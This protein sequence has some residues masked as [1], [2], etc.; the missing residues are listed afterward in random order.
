MHWDDS[1]KVVKGIGDKTAGLLDKLGIYTVGDLVQY[2]P[3]DYDRYKDIVPISTISP[4][5]DV[6]IEGTLAA[7]PSSTKLRNLTI[8]NARLKD[9]TGSIKV[10]WFNMPF[11][12]R[13]LKM[14]TYYIMRGKVSYKNDSFVIEQPRMY[15]KQE[16]YSGR[17]KLLPIY[18]LTKGISNNNISKYIQTAVNTVD[19]END[20][21]PAKYCRENSLYSRTKAIRSIHYPA[22]RD[23]VIKARKRLA[24][25]EFFLFLISLRRLKGLNTNRITTDA[26][27]D[28]GVCERFIENLP[29]KLTK[30]QLRVWNELKTD[31]MSG[32]VMSRL[33]QGD[34]GSGKTIL[35]AVALLFNYDNG[36]QGVIMAPTEVLA[37]QHYESFDRLY[38]DT[39]IR[40]GLLTG[41]M[42]VSAKRKMYEEIACGNIDVIVGT[43]AVIQEK[44]IYNRLGLVIT[45]EQ[46]RFGVRQRVDL[47]EKG[48]S[49]H[50]IVMSATPIPRTLAMIIYGDMDIS[51]VDE[52]PAGRIPIKNCVVGTNYRNA[53][54]KLMVNEV[55]AGN[56]VYIICPMIEDSED[57]DLESVEG[58]EKKLFS[59]MPEDIRISILHGKMSASEKNRI[60]EEYVAGNIDI[61]IS[62]T[63]IEVGINVP[64]A[65][66]M[67]IENSERF[68]LAAL[69][70]LRGRIGRGNRQSYCVF[71]HGDTGEENIKRLEVLNHSNDGFHIASEDLKLRGPGDLFGIMQ[72]GE[73]VFRYA[74]IYSDS[75]VLMLANDMVKSMDMDKVNELMETYSYLN[76]YRIGDEN[77][78]L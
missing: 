49:P 1:V 15:S 67:M 43:H 13:T 63:V 35:A 77:V 19:F 16:Y 36:Y 55:R 40:T 38:K 47:A 21:L 34:V 11:L 44:V 50:T 29:Y 18:R 20:Y 25:D 14:G 45:D 28:S 69:H 8:V 76:R 73:L 59:V 62:T 10:T 39:G 57:S 26:Y 31:M 71:M 2:Y 72:S 53:A 32:C 61:L 70:Q 68:G 75:D 5:Q 54:Y 42:T 37:K 78:G 12:A 52:L 48:D 56:Q 30:A 58:Y 9:S 66:V 24:F 46:H 6:V 27:R 64:S 51:V 60:M 4:G 23:D 22:D 41:S 7:R 74:D 3:R 65:T 17:N 33:I